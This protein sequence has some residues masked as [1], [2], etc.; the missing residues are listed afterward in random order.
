[1]QNTIYTSGW[2]KPQQDLMRS[3]TVHMLCFYEG[4]NPDPIEQIIALYKV[5]SCFTDKGLLGV[6]DETAWNCMPSSLVE[7]MF[8]PGMVNSCRENIPLE[9]WT[10]LV[11]F[12]RPNGGVWL[13]TK[14]N[15]RFGVKEFAYLGTV[16]EIKETRRLFA[17][18]F[19]YSRE[20]SVTF[21]AGE[22]AQMGERMALRFTTPIEFQEYLDSPLGTL[23]VQKIDLP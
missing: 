9:F 21:N 11:K 17:N 14:G 1:M 15:N 5:A 3:H 20:S 7:A 4:H 12:S 10:N 6:L 2:S 22:T 16:E 19:R 8:E 13:C 18:M 23:V